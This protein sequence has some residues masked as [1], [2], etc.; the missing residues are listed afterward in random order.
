ME[1]DHI[2]ERS[3]DT[4][5]GISQVTSSFDTDSPEDRKVDY[6]SS[7]SDTVTNIAVT[8]LPESTAA[9][10]Q[11]ATPPTTT[12]VVPTVTVHVPKIELPID[13]KQ[14]FSSSETQTKSKS[15][16]SSGDESVSSEEGQADIGDLCY[17]EAD[18]DPFDPHAEKYE[19][20]MP[21][22]DTIGV[23]LR[24]VLSDVLRYV[25]YIHSFLWSCFCPSVLRLTC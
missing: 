25:C 4:L 6:L 9:S 17:N 10:T 22:A 7:S 15:N 23:M 2:T 11:S 12:F 8:T 14:I 24:L 18:V 1:Q 16:E 21:K 3:G 13:A 20:L 19:H 5:P